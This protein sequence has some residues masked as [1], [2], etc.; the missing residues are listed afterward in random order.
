MTTAPDSTA[1]QLNVDGATMNG[2]LTVTNNMLLQSDP[3]I[4]TH[5]TN[6]GY[7]DATA[8]ALAVAFGA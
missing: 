5:A 6:K 2:D 7:V 3:T 8:T 4:G 1:S